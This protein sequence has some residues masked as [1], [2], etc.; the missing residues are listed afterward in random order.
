MYVKYSN[1]SGEVNINFVNTDQMFDF[2]RICPQSSH[3]SFYLKV[4][5]KIAK[6]LGHFVRKFV[7]Q[8]LSNISHWLHTSP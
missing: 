8:D 4:M 5:P 2:S 3:S 1:W 7:A 6:H